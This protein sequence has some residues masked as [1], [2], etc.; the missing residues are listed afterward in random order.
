MV[1][2][3]RDLYSETTNR[4]F[5]NDYRLPGDPMERPNIVRPDFRN[6]P[7]VTTRK[8]TP[9]DCSGAIRFIVEQIASGFPNPASPYCTEEEAAKAEH[10]LTTPWAF[11]FG[12]FRP[13]LMACV[14]RATSGLSHDPL[15]AFGTSVSILTTLLS[16]VGD[17]AIR[18]RS[19]IGQSC[20]SW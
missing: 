6:Q 12:H 18:P 11:Y 16:L 3:V 20:G 14:R 19:T 5:E 7:V 10:D 4:L 17:M 1:V 13:P 9:N 2:I 8:E 15:S